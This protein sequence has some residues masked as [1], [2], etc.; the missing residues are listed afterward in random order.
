MLSQ[1]AATSS[2]NA[3]LIMEDPNCLP[4]RIYTAL[5][6]KKHHYSSHGIDVDSTR[7]VSAIESIL[8]VAIDNTE[9][10]YLGTVYAGQVPTGHQATRT[11]FRAT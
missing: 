10:S 2:F 3:E 11:S 6:E 7:D 9:L 5:S 4:Q 1:Y 8:G